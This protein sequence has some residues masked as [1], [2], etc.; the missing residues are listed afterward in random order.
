MLS[1]STYPGFEPFVEHRMVLYKNIVFGTVH[2]V[3]NH[4]GLNPWSGIDATD[5]YKTP[6]PDRIEEFKSRGK[7]RQELGS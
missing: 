1:Q 5:S 7:S 4:N 3:G 6:R 2:V